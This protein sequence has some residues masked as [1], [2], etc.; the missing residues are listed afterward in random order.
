MLALL[1]AGLTVSAQDV[2]RP[3]E[4]AARFR[5]AN[6]PRN[7]LPTLFLVGDSTMK[8]GTPGQRG[9]GDE[10]APFF[11]PT[12]INVLNQA[13]GGR[14]SR[15]FQSEGRW[16]AVLAMVSTGDYVI[17][18]FG[19][20]D[21]GPVNEKPPVTAST[22]ARGSLRG[23]GEETQ[24]IDNILTRKHE[25]VH[26]FGWYMRE[27]LRDVQ[28]KGATPIVLSLTARNNWAAGKVT[29]ARPNNYAEWA[30]Q[31][32]RA[33]GALFV[34]HN[35]VIARELERLGPEQAL[36]LFADGRLHTSPDG[37]KF[38]ARMAVSGLKSLRTLP[39]LDGLSAKA[40][41]VPAAR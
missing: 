33:T 27:Y 38:N 32:A 25:V 1:A 19:H 3:V 2:D 37:A 20:N 15:T 16:E 12:R 22:R 28:A 34:D 4:D 18:Q 9:W 11:D 41:E 7:G 26:T 29:R 5:L 10:L 17:V 30:E 39:L 6:K 13:I 31:A 36:P 40:N 14:S 23:V 35:D 24:E 8:V 21:P